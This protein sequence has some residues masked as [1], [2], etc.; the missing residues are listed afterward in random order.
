VPVSARRNRGA[1]FAL[2]SGSATPAYLQVRHR[3]T[4][5]IRTGRLKPGEATPSE[6][7]LA[8]SLGI[9]RTTVRQALRGLED[10]GV[11]ERRH[12]SGTYVADRRIVQSLSELTG[13]SED[14]RARGQT[15]GARVLTLERARARPEEAVALGLPSGERVIRI[16]RLR[17]ADGE[18]L[19]LEDCAIPERVCPPL[20]LEDVSDRSLYAHL[21]RHGVILRRAVQR[22]RA[23]AADRPTA[24][25]LEL[26]P[27]DPVLSIQRTTWDDRDQPIEFVV[28][29]Y[30]GDRYDFLVEL[31]PHDGR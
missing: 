4:D 30:R 31:K 22:L 24:R 14:M 28:S 29:V 23:I 8:R 20:A 25:L 12:G 16:V 7:E 27:G 10:Q 21:A 2:D 5:L 11:L 3:L 6:R 13:F 19:A 26:S 9:S 17:T 1:G 15:P 18:P